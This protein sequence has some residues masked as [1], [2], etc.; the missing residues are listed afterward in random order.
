MV[1]FWSVKPRRN[2]FLFRF[3]ILNKLGLMVQHEKSCTSKEAAYERHLHER[4][5]RGLNFLRQSQ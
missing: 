3:F 4:S 2:K 5:I 1:S